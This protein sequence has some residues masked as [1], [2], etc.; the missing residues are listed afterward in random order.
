MRRLTHWKHIIFLL[1]EPIAVE[2][3]QHVKGYAEVHRNKTWRRHFECA[4]DFA[5][6]GQPAS[7]CHRFFEMWR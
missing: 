6:D 1:P 4:I 3:G 2:A 5:V 7:H